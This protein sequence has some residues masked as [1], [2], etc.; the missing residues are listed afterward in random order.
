MLLFP[1]MGPDGDVK[2][3]RTGDGKLSLNAKNLD[4]TGSV[5]IN[6]MSLSD[7]IAKEVAKA[8]KN[9]D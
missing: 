9:K 3:E 2:I 7:L 4:L 6:G 5:Y 8:L 1:Q